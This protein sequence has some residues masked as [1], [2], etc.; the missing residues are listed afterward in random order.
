MTAHGGKE[1]EQE[2]TLSLLVEIQTCTATMEHNMAV[3]TKL[4]MNGLQDTVTPK[5]HSILPQGHLLNYVHDGL[6]HNSQKLGTTSM[7]LNTRINKQN[8]IH[9]YN[10]ILFR[11]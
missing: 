2:N 9:I 5:G 11:Y 8:V 6:I 1:L 7:S 4:G 3:P 10:G